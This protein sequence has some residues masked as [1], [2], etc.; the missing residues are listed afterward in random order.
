MKHRVRWY[1]ALHGPIPHPVLER[2]LKA[3]SVSGK[4]AESL[5]TFEMNGQPIV[6]ALANALDRTE[7]PGRLRAELRHLVP[8]LINQYR[9]HYFVSGDRRFRLTVDSDFEF[10][11]PN[12]GARV[13]PA[14]RRA[15]SVVLELKYEIQHE[16]CAETVTNALPFR[17]ARCSKFIL[18]L[19]GV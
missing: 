17:L 3:G 1:G 15:P 19:E 5:A 14:S 16:T 10:G 2:K 8:C 12:L 9:R 4:E 18:G 7:L 13:F 6:A 11:F